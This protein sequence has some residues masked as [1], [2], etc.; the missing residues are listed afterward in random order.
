MEEGEKSTKF[1]FNLEKQNISKNTIRKLK[2]NDGSYTKNDADIMEEGRSFYENLYAS[3]DISD[4]EIKNYQNEANNINILNENESRK[5]EGKITKQECESAI[6]NMKN[7]KSPGSDGI[8]IE[9]YKTFWADIHSVLID[10]LNSAHETGELSGTQKR[11]I[12][13]LLYKKNDK[14]MLKNWRPIRL[15]NTDYKILTHVLANRLKS[16]I[17][18]L[19]HP[20]Q[21]G[22][23]KGRNIAY[24]IRLIQDVN[25]Y[26][27]ND[28]IKGAIIFLD[29]Q[30]AF[31]TV[32][33]NFL[34]SVL[35]KFNFGHSFIKGIQTIYTKSESCLSNNGWTS[36]PFGIQRGIR[37]GCPLSALLFLLVVEILGDRIRKNTH[38]GLEINLKNEKKNIQ[39]T[40]LAYDTTVFLK[41]NKRLRIVL[42]LY[43]FLVMYQV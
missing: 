25:N 18:K 37:Q 20:D 34:L 6:K 1:F 42:K 31:D 7:N 43:S 38:D 26:F 9:F 15:L 5:L 8:P 16:V 36:K 4:N 21:N 13:S 29:F 23:I 30:K 19:I 3:E 41:M 40:Q 17:G 22:Y 11:G 10:S 14:H 35:T 2:R 39:I 27:E 32:N 28:N 33:H 12:L 24:N